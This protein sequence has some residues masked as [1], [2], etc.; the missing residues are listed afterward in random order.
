MP[1]ASEISNF[2]H[3]TDGN[4]NKQTLR[5]RAITQ[6]AKDHKAGRRW[7]NESLTQIVKVWDFIAQVG[8]LSLGLQ[9]FGREFISNSAD[10]FRVILLSWMG[11]MQPQIRLWYRGVRELARNESRVARFDK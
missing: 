1:S 3:F 8:T 6:L 4:K 10:Y 11:L 7:A 9:P 2:L 5:F